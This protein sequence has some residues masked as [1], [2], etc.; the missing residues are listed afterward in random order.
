MIGPMTTSAAA[1]AALA[2]ENLPDCEATGLHTPGDPDDDGRVVCTT[3]P[4]VL[5]RIEEPQ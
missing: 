5:D 3:C 2:L 1:E 4:T